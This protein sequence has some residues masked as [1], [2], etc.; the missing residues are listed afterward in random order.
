MTDLPPRHNEAPPF[1][2]RQRA[3]L[4]VAPPLAALGIRLAGRTCRWTWTTREH[5]DQTIEAHGAA[6]AAF[7]HETVLLMGYAFRDTGFTTLTS[8]SF[9]GDLAA[10]LVTRMGMQAE[11]GSSSRGGR[12]AVARLKAVLE[13]GSTVGFP[14]DGPKGPRH[15]PKPGAAILSILTGVPIVPISIA[16]PRAW[17]LNTW[18]R[19]MLPRPGMALTVTCHPPIAPAARLSDRDVSATKAAIAHALSP[20]AGC[21]GLSGDG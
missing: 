14:V 9:D 1:T 18:D 17:R 3:V 8:L 16:A 11:R 7:W 20:D 10:R 4:A 5:W 21:D 2:R 13:S 19:L 12:R 6:I 15:E